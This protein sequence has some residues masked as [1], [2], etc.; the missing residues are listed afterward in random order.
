MTTSALL[1]LS[2]F[3][4]AVSLLLL[5]LLLLL[6]SVR[7]ARAVVDDDDAELN[8]VHWSESRKR[9]MRERVRAMFHHAFD[10]YMQL[11]FPADELKPLSCTPRDREREAPRGALDD[12]LGGYALTLVD[13][14]DTLFV[15][16]ERAQFE[17][18]VQ[19]VLAHVSFDRDVTVSVFE[20][21]IR[22]LGGLLSAHVFVAELAPPWY[23]GGLLRLAADLGQRLL[24][25]FATATGIPYHRVNLIH[26]VPP[27]ET[28]HANTAG[29]GTLTL[30]FGMLSRLTGDDRF[31]LAADGAVA[32]LY[33]RRSPLDLLGG[34]IDVHTGQWTDRTAS[35][36]AGGDSFYEYLFKSY[37]LFGEP[38]ALLMFNRTYEAVETYLR[39][40]H[41]WYFEV[42][43][44]SGD[45]VRRH[46]DSL[47]AFWPGLQAALGAVAAAEEVHS[48]YLNVWRHFGFLPEA[49]VAGDEHGLRLSVRHGTYLLRPEL[50]ESTY[51]LYRAT[52][53]ERHLDALEMMAD[54]LELTRTR[55]GFAC[56][57]DVTDSMLR[58][59][60][61]L[62]SFFLSE[63]LK[64]LYLAFDDDNVLHKRDV[65]FS[66]EGHPFPVSWSHRRRPLPRVAASKPERSVAQRFIDQLLS[67]A[68]PKSAHF[69]RLRLQARELVLRDQK[70]LDTSVPSA[71]L[72]RHCA[73]P[74][75]ANAD[76]EELAQTIAVFRRQ[77]LRKHAQSRRVRALHH[78]A[79]RA[80]AVP[81]APAVPPPPAPPAKVLR[82]S[83]FLFNQRPLALDENVVLLQN[84]LPA[85]VTPLV[86]VFGVR[87]DGAQIFGAPALFGPW[88]SNAGVCGALVRSEPPSACTA[89]LNAAAVAGNIVVAS[90]GDCFFID[91]VLQAQAAGAA[92]VLVV[93]DHRVR[94]TTF[95]A[96]IVGGEAD[97]ATVRIPSLLVA[98]AEFEAF[99]PPHGSRVCLAKLLPIDTDG[100]RSVREPHDWLLRGGTSPTHAH[101][102]TVALVDENNVAV[103]LDDG[104]LKMIEMQ[105]EA[106]WR[107]QLEE[108]VDSE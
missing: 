21:T 88:L 34:M 10:N 103:P 106:N 83:V 80:S 32:A 12:V 40:A 37:V 46:T 20:A 93:E 24:P 13:S 29:A 96:M 49:M 68:V 17:S 51:F 3:R 75:L 1:S 57:V 2:L 18:A 63:T 77:C 66:T 81:V 14:M 86:P 5:L 73:R 53:S 47:G 61:R 48:N 19:A 71:A 70:A 82:L 11:A 30:E 74:S 92:G 69:E 97:P 102:V 54:S 41:H 36:G 55:C 85:G 23:D 9:A 38:R 87:V 45:V 22:V 16:G 99:A 91:K 27:G 25:A 94:M 60:D 84:V 72:R 31:A 43:M 44:A 26:G 58:L 8:Q 95:D 62:D 4:V 98:Q 78:L 65:V 107:V 100:A 90:R 39:S 89:L 33:A 35:I 104:M 67:G 7:D 101:F 50:I 52:R 59:E 76:A 56:V 6:L 108:V 79:A 64:Y 105:L 15:M 28:T 42:D